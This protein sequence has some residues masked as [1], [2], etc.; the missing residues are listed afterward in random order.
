MFRKPVDAFDLA[1]I[2]EYNNRD[3][4]EEAQTSQAR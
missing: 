4:G 3:G 2:V 1:G